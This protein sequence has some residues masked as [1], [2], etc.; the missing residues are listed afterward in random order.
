MRRNTAHDH[1]AA[2]PD[3]DGL[4][5]C[6][7]ATNTRP[8][9]PTPPPPPRPRLSRGAHPSAPRDTE[10]GINDLA[11]AY[12]RTR[13][14]RSTLDALLFSYIRI[15]L[16]SYRFRGEEEVKEEDEPRR[17]VGGSVLDRISDYEGLF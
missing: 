8:T 10:L 6:I 1:T 13:A 16:S 2:T 4:A 9:T 3:V 17:D 15:S 7:V 11:C 5:V 14:S 12:V